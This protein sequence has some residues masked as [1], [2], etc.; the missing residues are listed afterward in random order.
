MIIKGD[1]EAELR[2]FGRGNLPAVDP[3]QDYRGSE[4]GIEIVMISQ[5]RSPPKEI[6]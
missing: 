6:G 3:E 4:N 5:N 2:H 1:K